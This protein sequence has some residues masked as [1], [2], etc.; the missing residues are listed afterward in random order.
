VKRWIWHNQKSCCG[1]PR[2]RPAAEIEEIIAGMPA[3]G[4]RRV[5]ALIRRGTRKKA[6]RR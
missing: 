6:G 3:D 2:P 1:R 4:Y 5:H